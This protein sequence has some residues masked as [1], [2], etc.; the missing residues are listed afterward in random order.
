M[1]WKP[2][3]IRELRDHLGQTQE[4]FGRTLGYGT[5][6]QQRVSELE[7]G[8]QQASGPLVPL[9]DCL[10]EKHRFASGVA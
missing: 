1:S 7:R 2:E 6:A 3:Q 5:G 9:L 8:V 4:A 10:A